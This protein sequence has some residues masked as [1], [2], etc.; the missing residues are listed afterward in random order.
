MTADQ[1]LDQLEPLV[2]QTLAVADRHTAQLKQLIN[3]VTQQSDNIQ[4]VLKELET[5]KERQIAADAKVETIGSSLEAVGSRIEMV[6]SSLEAVNSKI[7]ITDAKIDRI[8]DLLS[9]SK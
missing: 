2:S 6:S 4:F 5:V 7:E 1:R 9:G 3:L 8:L